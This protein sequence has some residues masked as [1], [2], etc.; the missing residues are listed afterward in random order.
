MFARIRYRN[1]AST[2]V[3]FSVHQAS[4]GSRHVAVIAQDA[5]Y[6][7]V[8]SHIGGHNSTSLQQSRKKRQ[9]QL[10]QESNGL[11]TFGNSIGYSEKTIGTKYQD[12][13][14]CCSDKSVTGI[15]L[16]AVS[17]ARIFECRGCY[18]ERA[19]WELKVRLKVCLIGLIA[20]VIR[21]R[22]SHKY[23]VEDHGVTNVATKWQPPRIIF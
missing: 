21:T 2:G 15:S 4:R 22:S 9:L 8:V 16:K 19:H 12:R 7:C 14:P 6:S 10:R 17:G 5:A 13:I 23:R 11:L 1:L 20:H 18:Q 3:V